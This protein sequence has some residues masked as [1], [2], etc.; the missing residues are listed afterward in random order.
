M[1]SRRLLPALL[2]VTWAALG[3][4]TPA[5]AVS[6]PDGFVVENAVTSGGVTFTFPT[7][8][9]FLP[10]GR[11]IV[12]EQGGTAYMVRNGVRLASPVWDGSTEILSN[13][14]RGLLGVTVDPKYFQ[15]HFVYFLYTVDPDSNGNDGNANAFGRLTR[16][17]MRATGDTNTVDP[18]TRTILMGVDWRHGKFDG[19]LSHSIGSLRWGRDGSLMVSAGEGADFNTM[20]A[21]GLQ[22][23]GFG[24]G[25]TDP[26]EDIGAFRAQD[27]TNLCGK[28]LRLN[29]A[30]G[31]GYMSNPFRD[32]DLTSARSRVFEYGLRNPFRFTVRPGT[33]SPDTALGNPGT[34]YIGDVGWGTWEELNVATQPG[35]NFGWPCY[36]GFNPQPAYQAGSPAHNGCGSVGTATNPSQWRKP[37]SVWHHSVPALSVPP[38]VFGVASIG[39]VFYTDSLYPGDYRGRYFFADYGGSW[40]RV[41]TFNDNDNLIDFHDFGS[42][43]TRRS[44]CS[45]AR[46]TATSTTSRS[47][48]ARSATS[49]TPGRPAATPRRWR[50]PRRCP[51]AARRR[52]R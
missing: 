10:D 46:S 8:L 7:A 14:D 32:S 15:N 21:G 37:V 26:N 47:P 39:G 23:A 35:L 22:P 9:A 27:I 16:Y 52:S 29:P 11:L 44:T 43:W 42:R 31:H 49:A 2:A 33:G 5:R 34:L 18:A 20:D 13:G 41:A 38:G 3:F 51:P 30:N 12:C 50:R 40:I 45:A 48:P 19:G 6:V 25:K 4:A 28:I 17:T 24:P 1:S 36:E